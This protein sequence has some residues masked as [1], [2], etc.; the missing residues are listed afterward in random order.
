MMTIG[1][2]WIGGGGEKERD[3]RTETTTD[4]WTDGR[5][6]NNINNIPFHHFNQY[7]SNTSG[8]VFTQECTILCIFFIADKTL[9]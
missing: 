2:D 3:E 5:R 7:L 4:G 9:G 1:L 6:N 8:C